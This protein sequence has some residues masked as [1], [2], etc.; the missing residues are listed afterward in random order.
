MIV[1]VRAI[2][3]LPMLVLA[4][5]SCGIAYAESGEVSVRTT[6][7]NELSG[8]LSSFSRAD[9][10]RLMPFGG[11][12]DVTIPADHVVRIVRKDVSS[13]RSDPDDVYVE[14]SGGDRLF[15]V[16]VDWP[17]DA[18]TFQCA[19]GQLTVPI[20]R[21][22][23]WV[24]PKAK[25]DIKPV[26]LTPGTHDDILFLANSD[27]LHGYVMEFGPQH[28]VIE[29]EGRE[30]RIKRELIQ[31]ARIHPLDGQ[32][33]AIRFRLAFADGSILTSPQIDWQD[34]M[35]TVIGPDQ[36]KEKVDVAFL[37]SVSVEGGRWV[38]LTDLDPISEHQKSMMSAEWRMRKK[39]NVLGHPL[40]TAGQ[41]F[42]NGIG[43]HSESALIYDLKA[44]YQAFVTQYG[45]DDSCGSY[46]DV[47]VEILVDGQHRYRRDHVISGELHGPL[48]IDLAGADRIELR[49]RFGRNGDIQDRFNW[50]EAALI[51]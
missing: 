44:D 5:W 30:I 2:P 25:R 27:Q 35:L 24:E 31:A 48:R 6:E 4:A 1:S 18:V 43:V 29:V 34:S 23:L 42:E 28:V 36:K 38:W 45:L 22:K 40:A 37:H 10:L 26:W 51:R 39:E 21:L 20:S 19:F 41:R 16:P 12:S 14:L 9:G 33:K 13:K 50:I 49:V 32:E 7:L 11:P 3:A 8:Q 15:G 47:D 17:P 46:A